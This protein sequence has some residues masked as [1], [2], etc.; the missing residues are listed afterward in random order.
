MSMKASDYPLLQRLQDPDRRQALK[1]KLEIRQKIIAQI[2]TRLQLTPN[3]PHQLFLLDQHLQARDQLTNALRQANLELDQRYHELDDFVENYIE[4]SNSDTKKEQEIRQK[5]EYQ[6]LLHQ[7]QTWHSLIEKVRQR[8]VKKPGDPLLSRLLGEH[9]ARLLSTQEQMAQLTTSLSPESETTSLSQ[10]LAQERIPKP[11]QVQEPDAQAQSAAT[12][13]N[14]ARKISLEREQNVLLAMVEKTRQ[15]LHAKPELLHL[16]ALIEQHQN[17][18]E[19][20]RSELMHLLKPDQ[21][22]L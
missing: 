18:L 12:Q 15:R 4:Q 22:L 2:E 20:I 7:Q 6:A 8:L 14:D 11:A 19:Q 10:I 3:D 16:K 9:Q 17:R 21:P 13:S 5:P 1:V